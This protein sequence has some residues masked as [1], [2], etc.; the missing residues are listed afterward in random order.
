MGIM[1]RII[2]ELNSGVEKGNAVDLISFLCGPNSKYSKKIHSKG[3][4]PKLCKLTL[5]NDV[6]LSKKALGALHALTS[7]VVECGELIL[8]DDGENEFQKLKSS[9]DKNVAAFAGIVYDKILVFQKKIEGIKGK[10][11]RAGC[12]NRGDFKKCGNCKAVCYC[13]PECQKKDWKRHKVECEE[14]KVSTPKDK[15]KTEIDRTVSQKWV[16]EHM[17]TILLEISKRNLTFDN[18]IVELDMIPLTPQLKVWSIEEFESQK[19][20]PYALI[21]ENTSDYYTRK[22]KNRTGNQFILL[23]VFEDQ[24]LLSIIDNQAPLEAEPFSF[25]G[26]L[27]SFKDRYF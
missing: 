2:H 12:E 3:L 26:M 13:G 7:N 5:S 9:K 17:F 24:F 16:T 14:F 20:D 4:I 19:E 8:A 6:S 22:K 15:K 1:S 25:L 11:H 27:S 23:T 18:C 10:C 21:T